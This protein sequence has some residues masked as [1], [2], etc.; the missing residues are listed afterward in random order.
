MSGHD[1]WHNLAP[2]IRDLLS[3]SSQKLEFKRGDFIYRSGDAPRGFYLVEEGLIAIVIVGAN[4]KDH[5]MRFFRP[6][7]FFG[8]RSLFAEQAYHASTQA[9][10]PTAVRLIP[11]SVIF[12]VLL[13]H[14]HL[15][16]PIVQQLALELR[17]CELQQV[18][19]LDQQIMPRVARAVVYLK[20]IHP[21]YR[22]TRQE[23]AAFCASTTSTVIKVLAELEGMG[24]LKQRGR[25]IEIID[26]AG[27]IQM[28]SS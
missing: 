10:E 2:E 22:W 11:K 9:L 23:L 20:D 5:L 14:P 8:H 16:A 19:L 25:E 24:L 7:Q 21:S 17:Q 27:L 28:S 18:M 3:K 1:L 4:G 13:S 26:R 6:G 12:S 15:Y